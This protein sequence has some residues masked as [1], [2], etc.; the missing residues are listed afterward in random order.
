MVRRAPFPLS[1]I[2]VGGWVLAG[3]AGSMVQTARLIGT[4]MAFFDGSVPAK[5][6]AS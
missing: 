1:R 4:D 2:P 3:A 5:A 6:C